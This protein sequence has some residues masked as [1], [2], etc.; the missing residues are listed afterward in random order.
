MIYMCVGFSLAFKG[1]VSFVRDLF[2]YLCFVSVMLSGL[3]IAALGHLLG[4]GWPLG[5]LVC[6]VFLCYS[7]LPMCCP[8]SGLVLD[9]IDS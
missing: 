3:S 8:G 5:S 7:H 9:C 4:K 6:D 1:G 2:C